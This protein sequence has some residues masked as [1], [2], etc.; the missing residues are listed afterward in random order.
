MDAATS[1]SALGGLPYESQFLSS[2]ILLICKVLGHDSMPSEETIGIWG[3][4]DGCAGFAGELGLF[5][6]L[7]L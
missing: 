1:C 4:V 5:V 6:Q 2:R 3:Q 7:E